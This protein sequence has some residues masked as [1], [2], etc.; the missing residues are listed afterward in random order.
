MRSLSHLFRGSNFQPATLVELVR[1]RATHERDR[2]AYSLLDDALEEVASLTYSEIDRRARA[3]GAWLQSIG[4]RGGERILLLHPPSPAYNTAFLGC[5]Y[6][7]NVAVPV[8]PPQTLQSLQNLLEI[9][10]N[11]EASVVLTTADFRA[12]LAPLLAHAPD[13][14][15]LRWLNTEEV[16]EGLEDGWREPEADAQ[17]LAMLQ[18][19]SGTTS[20]PKGVM[21]THDNLLYNALAA[22]IT[23]EVDNS[24][25]VLTWMPIYHT[26][27]I[28]G[29]VLQPLCGGYRSIQMSPSSFLQSPLRWVRAI[30]RYRVT[31]SGGPNFAFD[32]CARLA[33]PELTATLDLSCWALAF[34]GSESIRAE[35]LNR[36]AAA[37]ESCGFRRE[38]LAPTY[39]LTEATMVVSG[40]P[41][42]A[43]L[44][45]E[46]V[47][48]AGLEMNRLVEVSS[49]EEQ[50]KSLVGCGEIVPGQHVLIVDPET[51]TEC[52]PEQ[53]GE[54]WI[55]GRSI[56]QG[57]WKHPGET[58]NTFRG[59]VA[60]TGEGP[61]LRTGD[62]GFI[63]H[64]Q[65]F[66]TGRLKDLIIIRG[67]NHYPQDIEATVER[68]HPSVRPGA[69]AAF[70]VD[71][72][73]EERL[74]VV[75]EVTP[76][77]PAGLDL[78]IKAIRQA[79]A[80]EHGIQVYAVALIKEGAI[81]R[82]ASNKIQRAAC[83]ANFLK[84]DREYLAAS[85]ADEPTPGQQP[86]PAMPHVE[87]LDSPEDI[88][89]WLVAAIA[90]RQGVAA[91]EIDRAQ[92]ISHFGLDSLGAIELTHNI[93]TSFKI[94]LPM[95]RLLQGPSIAE[96]A[97]HI[98]DQ[99]ADDSST[100][101]PIT[102]A[103]DGDATSDYPLS[104]NQQSLW[105]MYRIA[106]DGVAYNIANAIRIEAELDVAAMRR[107]FQIMVERHA[108]LRTTFDEQDGEP[109][110]HV[111]EQ[112]EV[113]FEEED[114]SGWSAE[115]LHNRL[116]ALAHRPFRLESEP[117]FRLYLF[118][119]SAR[120]H[121]L[122]TV[123]HHIIT[124]LWSLAVMLDE[125]RVL[126]PALKEGKALSLAP[127]PLRYT[128]FAYWQKE[129]LE[130]SEGERLW[131]YWGK[132]LAG[133]LPVLNLPTDSPRPPV[134]TYR[135]ATYAFDLDAELTV[136]LK[137]LTQR[138]GAT[139]NMTLLAGFQLLLHRYTQQEDLLVGSL[140]ANRN[141][142]ELVGLV[143]Y[144]V[145]PLVMRAD[146]S[147]RP[148]V[149][150][151]LAQVRRTTLEALEH[152]D[153]PFSLLVERLQPERHPSR[154]PLFQHMFVWQ[155]ASLLAEEGLSAFALGAAGAR[156][157]LGDLLIQSL[158]L[159]RRIAQFDLT[160]F[161]TDLNEGI[162][163]SF[164]YNTDLFEAPT[165]KRLARQLQTIFRAMVAAPDQP[166]ALLPLLDHDDQR[167]LLVQWND[168]KREYP[169]DGSL[170]GLFE[171][172]V[173]RT[174]EATALIF[175][176]DLLTYRELNERANRLAHH[177]QGL[178]VGPEAPV[179]ILMERSVEM[180]VALLGVL[181]AGAAYAP[182]DPSHPAERLALM[183]DD[184]KA[185]VILTQQRYA[186]EMPPIGARVF[187]LDSAW[188]ILRDAPTHN[189]PR[190]V[191]PENIAYV[192][193]TSG[194]TGRP[195]GV[196]NTHAGI[197]NRLFWVQEAYPLTAEDAVLQKTPYAFDVSVWEF[198]WPLMT[199]ARLVVAAPGRQADSA[200]LVELIKRR[201]ITTIHFVPSML[202][203]FLQDEGAGTCPSLKR[204]ICSGE[205][206]PYDLQERFM[207]LSGAQ[208]HNL[209][210]PTEAAVEVTYWDCERESTR[211]I[212][213]I[214]RPIANTQIHLLD[215]ELQP[216]PVGVPGELHIAGRGLARGYLNRADLTAEKFI[217]NPFGKPGGERM[218]RT[219][220]LAR[221]LPDG[222]IEF[223]G[224][225]D[226]QVKV[227]G[228]RIEL[229]EIE[230]TLAQHEDVREVVLTVH[231]DA[232]GDNRLVA[233]IVIEGD[234]DA[235]IAS[236]RAFLAKRL[237]DYMVPSVFV[238]LSALPLTPNGKVDRRA[239]PAPGPAQPRPLSQCVASRTEEEAMLAEIWSGLLRLE[240]VGV[241]DNFFELGGHSLLATQVISRVRAATRLEL[242][243]RTLLEHPTIAEL[244]EQIAA[245]RWVA[246]G[247]NA[248][249]E[250]VTMSEGREIGEL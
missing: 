162:G 82:T 5:L 104:R 179:G 115:F 102:A 215:G 182:L 33:T 128:D 193:H 87:V 137:A 36:F 135:G 136:E 143:G 62:L 67:R 139:L 174:P 149:A 121:I 242:P 240:R 208:L 160:L 27:G 23:F 31:A 132:Q 167:Q 130:G 241:H 60:T 54:I 3:I 180:V 116:A 151:F 47:S 71:M 185:Q 76:P 42:A 103:T 209:Y 81:P 248:S 138:Y 61:F 141:R 4:A 90:H 206:L 119:R 118:R 74:V 228:F 157:Q 191:K 239:L 164:E 14:Q 48:A 226:H 79:I 107:A 216:V 210:G 95:W 220:D 108:S 153:Y 32:V 183:L 6:S 2:Q 9:V 201:Q 93:E 8:Y 177:L 111:H 38:A 176:D 50:V 113:F 172:Q 212:V 77:E 232:A 37:Y 147:E 170:H 184:L 166:V 146:L 43:P 235:T 142:A 188:H 91:A 51:L 229:G 203:V 213:P 1:W 63:R 224:R 20:T 249:S 52:T 68:S 165:I 218:Y 64:R 219:G 243:V 202:S 34:T 26:M 40:G 175:E 250:P 200:Y 30:S 207:S 65:L 25:S 106:P 44:I 114:A 16:A 173:G 35:S 211:K 39:G 148:T 75:Q 222:S 186:S 7:G 105:F 233:Y 15:R 129:M 10:T 156:L 225:L 72:E 66:V 98:I 221:Y 86:S 97:R 246:E 154:S 214:G 17:S 190:S 55:G 24:S 53:V 28:F 181:K 117:L 89:A 80:R 171:E 198:F 19:T 163:A 12:M 18:Y 73:N 123:I 247:M 159:E 161:M 204:V 152:Q 84:G 22:V 150:D 237:P 134:Q 133:A 57:Y 227:R 94:G 195:K 205:A 168:T 120:E 145:N 88:E 41:P 199:G 21:L 58:E 13:L 100:A 49:P 122:L 196:M 110:Q 217:P 69:G 169:A 112:M 131:S 140:T 197:C 46:E 83:R 194:S 223:L 230:T 231:P 244:A 234:T 245:L 96:L 238:P 45:T 144:L 124:D 126:Y 29:A 236:L 178:G 192:I 78:I 70:S 85:L 56:A 127:L 187:A 92:P 99:R 158:A 189:P 101:G 109:R 59:F 155:K 11:S 125:L